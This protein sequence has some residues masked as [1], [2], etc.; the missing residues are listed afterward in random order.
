MWVVT[1]S[2][3]ALLVVALRVIGLGMLAGE[4]APGATGAPAKADAALPVY[5]T[6]DPDRP[7]MAELERYLDE[8]EWAPPDSAASESDL[9]LS[10]NIV[11]PQRP[12]WVGVTAFTIGKRDFVPVASGPFATRG[13]CRRAL[14]EAMRQA[15]A[16]YVADHRGR[17][18][19]AELLAFDNAYIKDHLQRGEVYEETVQASFGPMLQQHSLL[20]F[21]Q[22]FR[23]EIDRRWQQVKVTSRL[24]HVALAA[25]AVLAGLAVVFFY[26]RLDTATQGCYSGRLQLAAGVVILGLVSLGILVARWIPWY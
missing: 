10:G 8:A 13:E 24:A 7:N 6:T 16:E 1:M 2:Y 22:E 17:E 4:A 23:D 21:G 26:L 5:A 14:A 19:I 20:E 25:I 9:S 3:Y 11:P 15:L 18:E 12:P